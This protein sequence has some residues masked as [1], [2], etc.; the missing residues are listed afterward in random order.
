MTRT[1]RTVPRARW[2]TRL[3]L[4]TA[5]GLVVALT[6]GWLAASAYF[7]NRIAQPAW[8][9]PDAV[10]HAQAV[11]ALRTV[12][13]GAAFEATTADGLVLRG[14]HLPAHPGND[15]FVVMLHGYG[16]NLL[17]FQ[18]Q[19]A[20]WRDLGFDVFLFD[21]RGSGASDGDF[22][23]AGL[24]ESADLRAVMAQA[25][26]AMPPG[27]KAG[28]YGRSGGGATAV[29]YAGQGGTADFLVVDC[30]YSS[31]SRQLLD[32]LRVD[33]GLLPEPL[34][35]PMLATTVLWVR[36]RFGIDLAEAEPL[37]AAPAIRIP[38][39]FVTTAG[40]DYVHPEMTRALYE[41]VPARKRLRVYDS[42]GHG[43]AMHRHGD[44]YRDE[45]TR[46]LHDLVDQEFS[47]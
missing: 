27:A 2:I 37:R 31:F 45:V 7:S 9:R 16:G 4:R 32:R 42:G 15:R 46:F 40:D 30:A 17:E 47:R 44:A 19:Y 13:A 35:R 23:S 26:K 24:L 12:A 6:L 34:H 3:A 33:Y 29:M 10:V 43:A 21:Q 36:G 11:E 25:R 39:L 14:L 5:A 1:D 38:T 8:R 20:F 28:V 22:L 41:A 18:V